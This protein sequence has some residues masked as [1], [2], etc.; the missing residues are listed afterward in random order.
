MNDEDKARLDEMVGELSA[1]ERAYVMERCKS[2]G[3]DDSEGADGEDYEADGEDKPPRAEKP[4]A[5]E[6]EELP[7]DDDDALFGKKKK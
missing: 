7:L 1:E 5:P 4:T 3:K 2:H 6:D